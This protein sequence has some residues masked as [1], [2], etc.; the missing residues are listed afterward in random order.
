VRQ[1][2]RRPNAGGRESLNRWSIPFRDCLFS[3][4]CEGKNF[5]IDL[6]RGVWS[7]RAER[8]LDDESNAYI[9]WLK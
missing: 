4:L 2:P 1:T 6:P 5:R 3:K 9:L 7:H 8:F